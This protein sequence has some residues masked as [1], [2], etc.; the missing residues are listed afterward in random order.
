MLIVS[1]SAMNSSAADKVTQTSS[2]IQTAVP[3]SSDDAQDGKTCS[4]A[5]A[6]VKPRFQGGDMSSFTVWMMNQMKY[7]EKARN[8]KIGG[9][10]VVKFTITSEGKLA[11]TEIVKSPDEMLSEEVRRILALSP[12]WTPGK[13]DGRN[14]DVSVMLPVVFAI[15]E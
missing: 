9:R 3:A 13:V 7:P 15:S 6:D 8:E 5:E 11:G 1:F 14:V 12:D 10:V 4:Y 2:T